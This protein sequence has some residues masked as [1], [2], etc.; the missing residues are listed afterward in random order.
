MCKGQ[1]R[2]E[3]GGRGW[4]REG[5]RER[6]WDR[7]GEVETGR[8]RDG[9]GERGREKQ[10]TQIWGPSTGV[11]DRSGSRGPRGSWAVPAV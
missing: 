6:G 8:E 2:E 7:M 10:R 3:E 5:E 11:T 4:E 1:E 9:G